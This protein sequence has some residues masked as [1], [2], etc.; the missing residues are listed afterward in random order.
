MGCLACWPLALLAQPVPSSPLDSFPARFTYVTNDAPFV[1]FDI[2][3]RRLNAGAAIRMS[4]ELK[5]SFVATEPLQ[6]V[7]VYAYAVPGNGGPREH[8]VRTACGSVIA[9]HHDCAVPVREALLLLRGAEGSLGLRVEAEGVGGERSTV[10]ITLP[11]TAAARPVPPKVASPLPLSL[12]AGAP[13]PRTAAASRQD[14][15]LH[16]QGDAA[17]IGKQGQADAVSGQGRHGHGG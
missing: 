4:R 5:L 6:R 17:G 9:G 11:V 2:A 16:H 7:D 14:G 12:L 15:A 10:R 13:G 8:P 3:P 1:V